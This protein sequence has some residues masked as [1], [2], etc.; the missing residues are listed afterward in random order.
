MPI[1]VTL[2]Q[3]GESVVEGTDTKWLVK[4]G[5]VVAKEQPLL[6]V[7]TDKADSEIPSP[8]AGTITK[9]VAQAGQTVPV[10]SVLAIL[11]PGEAGAKRA[12]MQ[13]LPAGAAP[14][15]PPAT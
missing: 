7:A 12:P 13:T 4:E 11:E 3:L 8:A 14:H 1:E 6:E 2:P 10:K 9:I 5:D 15:P